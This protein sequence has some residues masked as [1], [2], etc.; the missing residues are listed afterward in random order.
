[1][2]ALFSWSEIISKQWTLFDFLLCLEKFH[3]QNNQYNIGFSGQMNNEGFPNDGSYRCDKI[4][5]H[6]EENAWPP[7]GELP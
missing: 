4:L 3:C 2:Q 7:G 1:L 6:F 5:F